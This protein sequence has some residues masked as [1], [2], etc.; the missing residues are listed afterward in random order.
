MVQFYRY[1]TIKIFPDYK[2]HKYSRACRDRCLSS[3]SFTRSTVKLF[4]SE[5][6]KA[7]RAPLAFPLSHRMAQV[8]R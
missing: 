6:E 8:G 2:W 7:S 3:T 1:F 4:R 5:F